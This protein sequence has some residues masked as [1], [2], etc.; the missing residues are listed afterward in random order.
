M[1]RRLIDRRLAA[2]E[3]RL[4]ASLD[5]LRH[6]AR[7]SLPA[8][9]KF[10]LFTPMAR[11]RKALPPAAY[12]LARLVAAHA[13]DCGTC[14]QI[15]I[16]AARRARVPAETLR[17]ALEDRPADLA[18]PLDA[19]YHFARAVASGED[20]AALRTRLRDAYGEEALAELALAIASARV[21]PTVKRALGYATAC[22]IPALDLAG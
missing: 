17:A 10:S 4:G 3:A 9:F 14:V 11:H 1:L 22:S 2:E 20:D 16:N 13:E 5:Y 18:P 15:E 6:L 8:F 19:V 21:F 7:V 12:H